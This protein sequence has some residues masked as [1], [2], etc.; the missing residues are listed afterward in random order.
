[1]KARESTQGKRFR[2]RNFGNDEEFDD[3]ESLV[4][5]LVS[6]YRGMSVA[7]HVRG[8]P[9]GML[10]PFFVDVTEGGDLV[11]TYGEEPYKRV[12]I[13]RFRAAAADTR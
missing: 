2:I 6:N 1:M 5:G 3:V 8:G 11:E 10:R 13:E 7:V 9:T 4:E 12:D